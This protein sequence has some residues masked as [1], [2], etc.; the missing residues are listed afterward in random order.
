MPSTAVCKS[1]SFAGFGLLF[2]EVQ[3]YLDA[4]SRFRH[5]AWARVRALNITMMDFAARANGKPEQV[6]I[7]YLDS[8][9][10][11]SNHDVKIMR[12]TASVSVW[13]DEVR[14]NQCTGS[15]IW[16]NTEE[17]L[18]FLNTWWNSDLDGKMY[19]RERQ[20]DQS[21]WQRTLQQTE[22]NRILML[23]SKGWTQLPNYTFWENSVLGGATMATTI[24]QG[25]PQVENS[26][27]FI[28]HMWGGLAAKESSYLK[29]EFHRLE[30]KILDF[31]SIEPCPKS[32]SQHMYCMR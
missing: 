15:M 3:C 23:P 11:I 29:K 30:A 24:A 22:R 12:V 21:V 20:W 1:A 19:D 13:E 31:Q 7:V 10:F 8:D 27:P 28:R 32:F 18:E 26:V 16:A 17:A 14:G 5:A 4:T 6:A 2:N 25:K 9:A